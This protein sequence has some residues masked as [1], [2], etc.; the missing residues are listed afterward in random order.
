MFQSANPKRETNV[1]GPDAPPDTLLRATAGVAPN[2]ETILTEV[3]TDGRLPYQPAE[4]PALLAGIDARYGT[5][6]LWQVDLAWSEAQKVQLWLTGKPGPGSLV[7]AGLD[8]T[9]E[10]ALARMIEHLNAG[11]D[12]PGFAKYLGT[13]LATEVAHASYTVAIGLQKPVSREAYEK[14]WVGAIAALERGEPSWHSDVLW[15]LR[16]MMDQPTNRVH[17]LQLASFVGDLKQRDE[18]SK[19]PGGDR[20]PIIS[21]LLR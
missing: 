13:F 2:A 17:F 6:V 9:R 8:G 10:L 1:I 5:L 4:I 21:L 11:P 7:E 20:Y 18:M 12:L 19:V 15:F 3:R 16:A 14:A